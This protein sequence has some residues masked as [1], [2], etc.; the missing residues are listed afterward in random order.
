M[1]S[2]LTDERN[3]VVED[4]T[5]KSA[6]RLVQSDR[7]KSNARDDEERVDVRAGAAGRRGGAKGMIARKRVADMDVA[8]EVR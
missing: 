7:I 5:Y 6:H 1:D 4:A 2:H 3:S 8:I